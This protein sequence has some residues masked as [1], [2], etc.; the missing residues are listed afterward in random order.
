MLGT[1]KTLEKND[2][3]PLPWPTG[4]FSGIVWSYIAKITQ[5]CPRC[6]WPAL[7][8]RLLHENW[9]VKNPSRYIIRHQLIS[10]PYCIHLRWCFRAMHA[11][12]TALNSLVHRH[13]FPYMLWFIVWGPSAISWFKSSMNL[14]LDN[15]ILQKI[16][17]SVLTLGSIGYFLCG[18]VSAVGKEGSTRRR[19]RTGAGS[20]Q[21][22]LPP[23]AIYGFCCCNYQEDN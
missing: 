12:W 7:R 16:F 11:L 8:S 1:E 4:V 18:L 3:L 13:Q 21:P 5:S 22:V 17:I 6:M 23:L 9:R 10:W 15:L 2:S 19:H 20:T 14:R